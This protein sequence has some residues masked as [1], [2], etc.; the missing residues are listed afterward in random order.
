MTITIRDVAR[1]AGVGVATVSRVLN[2]SELV[3]NTTRETVKRAI[4]ELNYVPN[5]TARRLSLGRTMAI[6][7]MV[8]FFTRPSAVE[9]LRGVSDVFEGTSFNLV[10]YSVESLRRR[11]QYFR[12]VPRG[13]RV[14]GV[15]VIS[16]SPNADDV[17]ALTH[18]NLPVILLDAEHSSFIS[19]LEDS[20]HGGALATQHLIGLGH[21]R[22]AF[23]GGPFVDPFNFARTPSTKRL[24]GYKQ[25]LADAGLPVS[26]TLLGVDPSEVIG[27]HSI[28]AARELTMR[29]IQ[30]A[31]RPT[32]IVTASDTHAFGVM[33]AARELGLRIPDDLSIVGYDDIET[34]SYV[35][36]TTVSQSLYDSGKR[37]A[38]YMLQLLEGGDRTPTFERLPLNLVQ[39]KTTAAPANPQ[40]EVMTGHQ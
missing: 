29:M 2:D 17:R 22:I 4:A 19:L 13:D 12:E 21:R 38:E 10:V 9:R 34:A 39:R 27:T 20:A 18:S 31:D 25:T 40:Q 6:G 26:E 33:Q 11:E 16:M 15:I 32:G 24:E 23:I 1:R 28:T 37:S 7:V 5:H 3:S 35:E 30:Q 36:L 14:D 8:P